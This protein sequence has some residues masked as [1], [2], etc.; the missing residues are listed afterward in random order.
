MILRRRRSSTNRRSSKFVVRID[1]RWVTG[2]AQL[3]NA[4]FEVVHEARNR[5]LVLLAVVGDD[6]GRKLAGNRPARRLVNRLGP[7]LELRPSILWQLGSQVAHAMR[8]AALAGGARKA[9]LDGFDDAGRTVRGYQDRIAKPV[10][11]I[12]GKG[13]TPPN[14]PVCVWL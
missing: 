10:F 5:A 9:H 4:G 3:R 7:H 1:R 14:F 12:A 13:C 8:Q 11:R 2:E 6:A